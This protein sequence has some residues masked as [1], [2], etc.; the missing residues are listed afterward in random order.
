MGA[1]IAV[2]IHELLSLHEVG[3]VAFPT[4]SPGVVPGP[5][6]FPGPPANQVVL[7][8]RSLQVGYQNPHEP[9]D[10][11]S[12]PPEFNQIVAEMRVPA[13]FEVERVPLSVAYL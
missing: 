10:H 2:V 8:L 12:E 1:T 6:L 3:D 11:G 5:S 4:D 13:E 9:L 7:E